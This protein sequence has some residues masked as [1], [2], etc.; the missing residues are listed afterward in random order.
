MESTDSFAAFSPPNETVICAH[1]TVSAPTAVRHLVHQ[2]SSSQT[3]MGLC[4]QT[5][6]EWLA[7]YLHQ[8]NVLHRCERHCCTCFYLTWLL[9][10][11]HTSL[12]QQC[13]RPI[14]AC[15]TTSIFLSASSLM[16]SSTSTLSFMSTATSK[17]CHRRVVNCR[18]D[19][20]TTPDD[21]TNETSSHR[22]PSFVSF[23]MPEGTKMIF[24]NHLSLSFMQYALS[25]LF[26]CH[27]NWK[28]IY[29]S[30]IRILV[31]TSHAPILTFGRACATPY[32]WYVRET[33]DVKR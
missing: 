3:S 13:C 30:R 2:S 33:T 18:E 9:C 32:C 20:F 31:S 14:L 27:T 12:L 4:L 10:S 22:T 1:R 28:R 21:V 16:T 23:L 6:L 17:S 7:L 25:P 15:A 8:I 26:L 29:A 11:M 19:P 24:W 5:T